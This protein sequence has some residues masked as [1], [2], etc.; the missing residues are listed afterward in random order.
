MGQLFFVGRQGEQFFSYRLWQQRRHLLD[1][2]SI[3]FLP[4]T[5]VQKTILQTCKVR[6]LVKQ[7]IY[8]WDIVRT[9]GV[10]RKNLLLG[11]YQPDKKPKIFPVSLLCIG[12]RA[13]PL[14]TACIELVQ[15]GKN[16]RVNPGNAGCALVRSYDIG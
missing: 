5:D 8:G 4:V 12:Q 3:G 10:L 6:L 14:D 7:C 9:K 2:R 13:Q 15:H 16:C 11:L 1:Q